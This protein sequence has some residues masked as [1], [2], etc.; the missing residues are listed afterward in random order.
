[1]CLSDYILLKGCSDDSDKVSGAIYVNGLPG[2]KMK[3]FA[4]VADEE[5]VTGK[6]FFNSLIEE[7]DDRVIDDLIYLIN[8]NKGFQ[9][10]AMVETDILGAFDYS[11]SIDPE[12]KF[13]GVAISHQL[14]D[15]HMKMKVDWIELYSHDKVNKYVYIQTRTQL[16]TIEFQFEVG[17][18][19]IP[20]NYIGDDVV[21]VYVNACNITLGSY[22][23]CGCR[24]GQR[25]DSCACQC[26]YVK[27]WESEELTDANTDAQTNDCPCIYDDLPNLA[28]CACTSSLVG[29]R[30]CVSCVCDKKEFFCK[31]VDEYKYAARLL[32]G[33]MLHEENMSSDSKHPYVRN[34]KEDSEYW[35]AKWEGTPDPKT[36]FDQTSK[37]WREIGKAAA[38]IN[39]AVDTSCS[40]CFRCTGVSLINSMP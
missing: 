1:M 30:V 36:G 39:A 6:R 18:N 7:A 14:R 34:S 4:A 10:N 29:Y 25:C 38:R 11:E 19:R 23:G 8:K 32:I 33:I 5:K 26:Y 22:S 27:P 24:S 12:Q 21:Y 3:K 28:D 16:K 40:K 13:V 35:L 20:I 37:Y 17:V 15:P 31:F 2:I 9:F